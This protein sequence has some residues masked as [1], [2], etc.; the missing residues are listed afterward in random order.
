MLG[1]LAPAMEQATNSRRIF[2]GAVSILIVAALLALF[3]GFR[4][5][6]PVLHGPKLSVSASHLPYYAWGSFNRMLVAYVLALV[7]SIT[8]GM[9][10]A[11]VPKLVYNSILSWV[12]GWYFLIACEIITA[13]PSTYRLP[14]LG[15]FLMEAANRGRN[16]EMALGL[17]A[18]LLIIVAMDLVVWQPLS[19]WAEK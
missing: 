13:G 5:Y 14:G 3:F 8:Y 11:C 6:V 7:F 16:G 2:G 4:S 18:L 19:V 12:A 15:T 10:A 1:N 9:L 17:L